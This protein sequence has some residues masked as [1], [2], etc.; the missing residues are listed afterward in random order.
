MKNP[1]S[2]RIRILGL[3]S[4]S[5]IIAAVTYGFAEANTI[6]TSGVMGAGYGVKSH[7]QVTDI[8]YILDVENPTT[9]TAVSFEVDQ[10]AVQVEAGVSAT[11]KGRIVWAEECLQTGSTF[12]CTFENSVDVLAA[13]WLHVSSTP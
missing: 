10:Q 1:K 8:N 12:I 6:H 3:V 2:T 4:L 5:L 7:F 13:D 9:F 11:E